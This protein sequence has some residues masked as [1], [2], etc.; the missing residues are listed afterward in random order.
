MTTH[1]LNMI[2]R[3]LNMLEKRMAFYAN[4]LD[5]EVLK[6]SGAE[7]AEW[8]RKPP[9]AVQAQYFWTDKGCLPV[10]MTLDNVRRLT[11]TLDVKN[12]NFGA[13]QWDWEC[14]KCR[15]GVGARGGES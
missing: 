2:R 8:K 7:A 6:L 15:E 11:K 10:P 12:E 4:L 1:D 9:G 5:G 13:V 3:P 14:G